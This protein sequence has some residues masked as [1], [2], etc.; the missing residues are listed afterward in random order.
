MITPSYP[1]D[2]AIMA[3]YSEHSAAIFL[4]NHA[5]ISTHLLIDDCEPITVFCSNNAF[6]DQQENDQSKHFLCFLHGIF[7]RKFSI[8]CLQQIIE[9]HH[10]SN[11]IY[12]SPNIK[13]HAWFDHRWVKYLFFVF[14]L[15]KQRIN[16]SKR[17][18][19]AF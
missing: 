14:M 7:T 2:M 16:H 10:F 8:L 3:C 6:S 19:F 12:I 15:L 4:R 18:W 11:I 5:D 9:L 1:N 13:T 17:R